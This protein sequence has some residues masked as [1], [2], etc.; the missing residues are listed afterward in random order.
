MVSPG[1]QPTPGGFVM[2]PCGCGRVLR[3][4]RDQAGTEIAC[5]DCRAAHVVPSSRRHPLGR[6]ADE[7]APLLDG[8][9]VAGFVV[10]VLLFAATL[11]IPQAGAFLVIPLLALGTLP[12][13]ALIAEAAAA[14][15]PPAEPTGPPTDRRDWPLAGTTPARLALG[16]PLAL[17]LV[18]PLWLIG[19]AARRSPHLNGWSLALLL[20]T[21]AAFPIVMAA[22]RPGPPGDPPGPA[23]LAFVRRHPFL[24]L[25]TLA[26]VP[27]AL[28]LA[29]GLLAGLIFGSGAM[30]V[31]VLDYL[32][33]AGPP[34]GGGGELR[35][36]F[37][38]L[39]VPAGRINRVY[40][41]RLGQ[42]FSFLGAIPPSLSLGTRLDFYIYRTDL[43]PA[44]YEKLRVLLTALV[45]A[46]LV[47][48][49]AAQARCLG[50]LARPPRSLP[51]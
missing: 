43:E 15:P 37:R 47:A 40:P 42:G 44:E 35:D 41:A 20:T 6:L 46:A 27:L 39:E 1:S 18:G 3:A 31:F 30:P 34:G 16:L 9:H 10:A 4:R 17:G 14:A 38:Y 45:G 12:Y 32:P 19:S 11:C 50:I 23:R 26:I 24:T 51:A 28:V 2:I 22:T 36:C 49:G 33:I 5:W 13:G 21:C 25:A 8:P 48:G 29:E 7:V